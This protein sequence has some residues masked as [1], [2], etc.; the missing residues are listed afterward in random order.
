ML[1]TG[2]GPENPS[3]NE[4]DKCYRAPASKDGIFPR[5]AEGGGVGG[6]GGGKNQT[7][8]NRFLPLPMFGGCGR[9]REVE[10]SSSS[11]E[12]LLAR[13]HRS[14]EFSYF[15]VFATHCAWKSVAPGI[16]KQTLTYLPSSAMG[17]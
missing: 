8:E 6:G 13:A 7:D 11:G 1:E 14:F 16:R 2:R 5:G 17:N 4:G 10:F 3:K 15:A 12:I 9:E